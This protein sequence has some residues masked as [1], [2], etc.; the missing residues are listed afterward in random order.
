M[1]TVHVRL[2]VQPGASQKISPGVG[3]N[4]TTAPA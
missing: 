3:V 1:V 2:K 4:V